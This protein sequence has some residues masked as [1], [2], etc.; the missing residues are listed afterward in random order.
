MNESDVDPNEERMLELL[1][2]YV[3]PVTLSRWSIARHCGF[4]PGVTVA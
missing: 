2:P 1:A 4:D 3:D